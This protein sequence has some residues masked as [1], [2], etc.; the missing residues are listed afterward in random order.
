MIPA[1][2]RDVSF[3]GADGDGFIVMAPVAG[4]LT[5]MKTGSPADPG[6]RI[7]PEERIEGFPDS[8]FTGQI[9]KLANRVSSRAGLLTGC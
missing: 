3:Q 4:C 2:V 7:L 9:E 8:L 6:E 1:R 5:G